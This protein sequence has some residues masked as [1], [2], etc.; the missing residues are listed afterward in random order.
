MTKTDESMIWNL[1]AKWNEWKQFNSNVYLA[2]CK[3][4]F[5]ILSCSFA[6][7]TNWYVR[8]FTITNRFNFFLLFCFHSFQLKR[9]WFSQ[10]LKWRIFFAFIAQPYKPM[11]IWVI[12]YNDEFSSTLL[13]VRILL[14]LCTVIAATRNVTFRLNFTLIYLF[15]NSAVKTRRFS[16]FIWFNFVYFDWIRL[17]LFYLQPCTTIY[18]SCTWPYALLFLNVHTTFRFIV[19]H[20]DAAIDIDIYIC[21]D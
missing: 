15:T 17:L 19:A 9:F 18:A 10:N 20:I 7:T 16:L 12:Q 5:W 13:Y 6:W 11:R 3:W 4:W 21:Y 2:N 14:L 1:L 8:Q